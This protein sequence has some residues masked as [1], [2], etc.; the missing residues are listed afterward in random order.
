MPG[1]M[2]RSTSAE[3]RKDNPEGQGHGG[4][5]HGWGEKHV[6]QWGTHVES[7]GALNM[8]KC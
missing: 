8:F 2:E 3:D 5:I 7:Q 4:Q 1:Y 6:Q